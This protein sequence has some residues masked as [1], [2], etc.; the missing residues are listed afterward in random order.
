MYPQLRFSVRRTPYGN[1]IVH[2]K[3]GPRC[4][5]IEAIVMRYR[6]GS[7]NRITGSYEYTRMPWVVVF[8]AAKYINV[9]REESDELVQGAIDN[10]YKKHSGS[11]IGIA[12][13]SVAAYQGG[14][15]CKIEVPGFEAS[16]QELVRLEVAS[17]KR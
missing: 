17:M 7:Y 10:L 6:A 2:W 9:I 8:G 3:D 4:E 12:K 14:A 13:P 1:V 16:L 5:Q 15:L 11:L